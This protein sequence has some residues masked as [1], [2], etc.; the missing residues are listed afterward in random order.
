MSERRGTHTLH[1][2]AV[3]VLVL[4]A[5]AIALELRLVDVAYERLGLGPRAALGLLVA[6][7]VGSLF[8]LPVASLRGGGLGGD[9]V[10]N[11]LDARSIEPSRL[12]PRRTRIA[13]NLGGALIPTAF[14]LFLLTTRGFVLRPLL[15]VAIVAAGAYALARPVRGVGIVVPTL[16]PPL[17]AAGGSLLLAP[18]APA[19]AAYVG[20]TLGT[21]LGGDLLNLRKVRSLGAPRAS[22]GGAGTFDGIFLA[23][24]LAV[25]L[26]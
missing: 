14:S 13:V 5:L 10:A 24:V 4:L 2:R 23:G 20:G 9:R 17:L 16:V 19:I 7:L 3:L 15:V 22:I 1:P 26:A 18:E 25:L 11:T 21:L 8:D 12:E 6:S